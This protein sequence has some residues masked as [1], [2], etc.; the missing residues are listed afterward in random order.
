MKVYKHNS[1]SY[2]TI[3]EMT[4]DEISKINFDICK[5]PRETPDAYYKRQTVKPDV[6]TNAG[7]FNMRDGSTI[8]TVINEQVVCHTDASINEG[9]GIIGDKDLYLAKSGDKN[10][11]DF[12]SAYP[13]LIKDGK[14]VTSSLAKEINY[15]A[16]RTVFAYNDSKIWII[17]VDKPGMDFAQ[18]KKLCLGLGCKYA[19]NFDGGGS[20]RML[21]NGVRKTALTANRPVDSVLCIYLKHNNK[22]VNY[23]VQ[24]TASALNVRSGPGTT[25]PVTSTIRNK[26]AVFN[27]VMEDYT[28]T[29]GKLSTGEGWISLSYTKKYTQS[30]TATTT[31]K[32]KVTASVLR[33]RSGPGTNYS[34]VGS[35]VKDT[36]VTIYAQQ[37]GWG[38]IADNSWVSLTYIKKI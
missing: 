23:N 5:Q 15:K 24:I 10:W 31:W 18:L 11:R 33:V 1:Y 25:Y 29:W 2:V 12:M 34:Q 20:T 3:A 19:A 4:K 28:S 35:K 7:L 13:P 8:F 6:I 38:K 22:T 17:C 21:V 26:T 36:V 27:I 30:T 37:N 16:R 32:G 9:I 14:T